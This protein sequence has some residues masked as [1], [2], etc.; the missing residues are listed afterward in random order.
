MFEQSVSVSVSVGAKDNCHQRGSLGQLWE[1]ARN[2]R[3]FAPPRPRPKPRLVRVAGNALV[4]LIVCRTHVSGEERV[5]F[6]AARCDVPS[7]RT[8]PP[9]T[10][11]EP[12]AASSRS[13][14][15][16]DRK[17]QPAA[18]AASAASCSLRLMCLFVVCCGGRE[19]G[20][21][22]G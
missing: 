9:L 1:A 14:V 10:S 15:E 6:F 19:E 8:P 21:R 7:Q 4:L 22:G 18:L 13:S 11:A 17:V 2:I 5:R 3:G 12:E 20:V 16:A